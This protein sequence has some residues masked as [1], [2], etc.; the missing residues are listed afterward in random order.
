MCACVCAYISFTIITGYLPGFS[1]PLLD[2]RCCGT[3]FKHS[4][5]NSRPGIVLY[6][7]FG[8]LTD[9]SLLSLMPTHILG[10]IYPNFIFW[11]SKFYILIE[12]VIFS[13]LVWFSFEVNSLIFIFRVHSLTFVYGVSL[14]FILISVL[15]SMYWFIIWLSYLFSKFTWICF[16]CIVNLR[17]HNFTL[18]NLWL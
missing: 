12:S 6:S 8:P 9:G 2:Y 18:L 13:N 11:V 1:V 7:Y 5:W 15:I 3:K 10:A 4:H 17:I 14:I 16:S